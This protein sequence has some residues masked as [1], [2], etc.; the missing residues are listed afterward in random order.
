MDVADLKCEM[1]DIID[2]Q[3]IV[4]SGDGGI[5][6]II[7]QFQSGIALQSSIASK[8]MLYC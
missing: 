7:T 6:K 1:L 5:L 3:C 8:Q 2:Q 4:S